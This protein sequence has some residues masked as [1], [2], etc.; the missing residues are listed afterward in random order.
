MSFTWPGLAQ[1]QTRRSHHARAFTT[2]PYLPWA[3]VATLHRMVE[4]DQTRVA[5][6][7][8]NNKASSFIPT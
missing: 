4:W 1:L 3:F 8:L 6:S 7:Q 5:S 2:F